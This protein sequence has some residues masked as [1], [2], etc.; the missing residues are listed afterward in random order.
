MD[1]QSWTLNGASCFRS[2][3][4]L[5]HGGLGISREEN[6]TWALCMSFRGWPWWCGMQ[7]QWHSW[8]G[9]EPLVLEGASPCNGPLP[10]GAIP[11]WL[12]TE[13]SFPS[14][15]ATAQA[16]FRRKPPCTEAVCCKPGLLIRT[17]GHARIEFSG[18][19]LNAH[20]CSFGENDWR[21]HTVERC[22]S[23]HWK[24]LLEMQSPDLYISL[25]TKAAAKK[26]Q[27]HR[28]L[29][30]FQRTWLNCS[31]MGGMR[32]CLLEGNPYAVPGDGC[33]TATYLGSL[34]QPSAC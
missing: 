23:R 22:Y 11:G 21:K 33:S 10:F 18:L 4:P 2:S 9:M 26:K 5:G 28:R 16:H 15:H 19:G 6:W 7:A 27:K 25:D 20:V 32:A 30:Y 13:C 12:Q 29:L 3:L 34:D 14:G 31:S 1:W 24:G 17:S 8:R